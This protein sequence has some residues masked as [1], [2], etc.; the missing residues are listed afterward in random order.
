MKRLATSLFLVMSVL[1]VISLLLQRHW[2][3][4][5]YLRSA[6]EGGMVGALADWFA[7][8]ALFRHP[9]GLPIP[10]TNLI[11]RKKDELGASL[12]GFVQ[13]NFL[14]GEVVAGKLRQARLVRRAGAYLAGE[15]GAAAAAGQLTRAA[16]AALDTL[17]DEQV[18]TVLQALARD[19]VVVP[20]WSTTLGTLGQ[21]LVQDGHHEAA[22]QLIARRAEVWVAHNPQL[23]AEVVAGRSPGW[24]P[25]MVDELLAQ[26]IHRELTELLA[27]V[28]SQSRHPV[29][30]A[31]TAWLVDFTAAMQHDPA[32]I[33][34]VEQFKHSL[35]GDPQ[36]RDLAVRGWDSLK[37]GL[38]ESLQDPESPLAAA[39]RG[40]I[41]DFGRR[42]LVDAA[43][44]TALEDRLV[45]VARQLTEEH[46]ESLAALVSDTVQAWDP[47][48]ASAKLELQVGRDLQFIRINGTVIG[49]LAGVVIYAAG[50]L[51]LLGSG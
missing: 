24:V 50:Q 6:A 46:G 45:A 49:A 14:S 42:L 35:L 18:L 11:Q 3:A 48:E 31:V 28:G 34:K 43:L 25:R 19:Y 17:D 4:F 44:R 41:R 30:R 5:G 10:H 22:V 21:K 40:A 39:I 13:E 51:I 1:F 9:L 20:E 7:V 27:A 26:K 32:T 37:A 15:R 23:F 8:T 16:R 33:E 29:R 2:P 12:G 38:S 36:L 47:A